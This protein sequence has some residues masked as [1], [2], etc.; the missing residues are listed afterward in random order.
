ML[1]DVQRKRRAPPPPQPQRLDE[2]GEQYK[3]GTGKRHRQG[4]GAHRRS[5]ECWMVKGGSKEHKGGNPASLGEGTGW[6]EEPKEE[7]KGRDIEGDIRTVY[8]RYSQ[9]H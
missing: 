2:I 1:V 4:S 9:T 6:G 5:P 8:S 7:K 3:L